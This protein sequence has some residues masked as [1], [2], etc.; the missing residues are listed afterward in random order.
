MSLLFGIINLLVVCRPSTFCMDFHWDSQPDD[1]TSGLFCEGTP[2]L[3]QSYY[4]SLI[5]TIVVYIFGL[6]VTPLW[7]MGWW[8]C[9]YLWFSSM[10]YQCLAFFPAIYNYLLQASRKRL[11]F[12][13]MIMSSLQLLNVMILF[14]A[15]VLMK[16]GEGFNHYNSET[17]EPNDP[18]D[19]TDG[20]PYNIAVL[21]FYLFGPFWVIYFM[22]GTVL[23][24]LYDTI[25]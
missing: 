23:A 19:Y 8:M 4:G 14:S 11:G 16:R 13:L 18:T 3:K 25:K 20:A 22:I 10:Y 2:M 24:F 17:G 15:W 5:L 9:Y 21:S 6:A 1:L 12:L 7:P